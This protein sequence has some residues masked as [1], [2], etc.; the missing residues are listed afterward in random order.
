MITEKELEGFQTSIKG[1]IKKWTPEYPIDKEIKAFKQKIKR[2][3][4]DGTIIR[5]LDFN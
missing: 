5:Y 1:R 3:E 2:F 4:K